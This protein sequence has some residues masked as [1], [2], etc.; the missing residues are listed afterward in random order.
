LL[1]PT[2]IGPVT[3]IL[4]SGRAAFRNKSIWSVHLLS[5]KSAGLSEGLQIYDTILYMRKCQLMLTSLRVSR[6]GQTYQS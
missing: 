3:E 6:R 1:L 4:T 2:L 5:V